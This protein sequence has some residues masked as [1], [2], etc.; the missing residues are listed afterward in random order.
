[1]KVVLLVKQVPDTYEKRHIAL[2]TGLL[3]RDKSENVVD[4]IDERVCAVAADLK[5]DGTATEVV[6]V[7]MGP[8]DADKA[9]RK[10]LALALIV[11]FMWSMT[12]W[13]V[14]IWSK[15]PACWLQRPKTP[16]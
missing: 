10:V 3:A 1:M 6:A 5:K 13:L 11:R 12:P 2:D 7:T 4:E 16:I 9:I 8:A 15:R 14:R